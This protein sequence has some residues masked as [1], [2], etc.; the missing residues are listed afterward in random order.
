VPRQ[1]ERNLV[2]DTP[3]GALLN[4]QQLLRLRSKGRRW[5]LTWKGQ[6]AAG[7]RHKVREEIEVELV[8][9]GTLEGILR[10]LGLFAAFRYEKYRTEFRQSGQ[11]GARGHLLL[12]ETPIGNFIELEG[13]PS[14]IDRIAAEL[15]Y[16]PQD[17]V[18][19]SYGGLYFAYC[20]EQGQPIGNM[21][22]SRRARRRG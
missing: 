1:L 20:R 6:P 16:K 14:W 9:G 18:V 11:R 17:Y 7:S 19:A 5:W 21:L 12:D 15:G 13:P 3:E 8:E 2:F 22:F 4:R 10:Q